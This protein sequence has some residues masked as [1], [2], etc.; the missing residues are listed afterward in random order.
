MCLGVFPLQLLFGH[1]F[2]ETALYETYLPGAMQQWLPHNFKCQ[3]EGTAAT[4]MNVPLIVM[5]ITF[6]LLRL[7][8]I[9]RRCV[10][11]VSHDLSQE[12][13]CRRWCQLD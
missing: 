3:I 13:E 10:T 2:L 9:S 8:F 11:F 1:G 7:S 5:Y 12:L 6:D 4:S